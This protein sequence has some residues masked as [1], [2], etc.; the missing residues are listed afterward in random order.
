V[1]RFS[2]QPSSQGALV[3]DVSGQSFDVSGLRGGKDPE[4]S[5][6]RPKEYKL[7]L[8]KLYTSD[9]GFIAD[10]HGTAVRDPQGWNAISLHGVADG[11]QPLD[12]ELTPQPDG[13]RVFWAGCEDFGEALKGLG[14]TDT[15]KGG[16]LQINGKSA[17]NNPRVIDGTVKVGHF[18]VRDLPALVT[19]MNATSPTG[20]FNLFNGSMDF[21]HLEGKFHWRGDILGLD[22]VRAA[23][24]AAG[25]TVGGKVDMNTGVSDLHGAMAPFSMFNSILGSIPIIGDMITGGEG[26]GVIA[27]AYTVKGPLDKP[28]VSVNPVSLLTP[29]FLR[30][31]FFNNGDSDDS[32]PPQ[33]AEQPPVKIN[34][35]K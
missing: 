9:A 24:S 1:L 2:Q 3:F 14:F 29:G 33:P 10:A 31:L 30:N 21:D 15:V 23:G 18:T 13:R 6:P 11:K 17:A 32:V 35:N 5:D 4:R 28:D 8:D 7:K 25:I 19:L 34:I 26:Q 16:K 20:L 27:A 22:N 12:M